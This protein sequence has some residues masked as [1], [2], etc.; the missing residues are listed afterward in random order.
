M[1]VKWMFHQFM[2]LQIFMYR[3]SRGKTF[4]RVRGMPVLLL[5]TVGRKTGKPRVTPV[6]YIRD[7]DNYVITA[8]YAGLGKHPGWFF[9]LMSNPQTTIE[10]NGMTNGVTAHQ[11]SPT[12]KDRLWKQLVEQAPFF[13][14][15][16]KKTTRDI[17]M[18]ILQP[19]GGLSGK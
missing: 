4:G 13:E 18:V 17:P 3:R 2:R 1:I 19:A 14:G 9:N 7:G 5:T 8:S 11:A 10:V 15:Y 6:M 12:E 16:R